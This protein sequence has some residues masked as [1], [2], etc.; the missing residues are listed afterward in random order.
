MSCI[1]EMIVWLS[2]TKN[3]STWA[4]NALEAGTQ[5]RQHNNIQMV[6]L[7]DD[8]TALAIPASPVLCP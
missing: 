7:H 2:A 6:S 3:F 8:D 5:I 1:N 4:E